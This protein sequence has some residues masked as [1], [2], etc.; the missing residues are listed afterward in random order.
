VSV[1]TLIVALGSAAPIARADVKALDAARLYQEYCA[2]CHGE[3]GDGKSRASQGLAT[4]PRNFTT[5]GL[6]QVLSRERMI[7][8]VWNGRP[9]TAMAA[10]RDRLSRQQVAAIVDFVRSAIMQPVHTDA[11][12]RGAQIYASSCSVCH[13]DRGGGAVW[14]STALQPPPRDFTKAVL[15]RELMVAVVTNGRPTTAMPAFGSQLSPQDIATVVDYI[16]DTFMPRET[17][18][19]KRTAAARSSAAAHTRTMDM[20]IPDGLSGDAAAGRALYETNCVACHGKGGN[21]NGPRAYFIFPRPRNFLAQASRQTLNRPVL[22]HAIKQGIVGREMPAW[23]KVLT[24]QQIADIAE[25]VYQAFIR[26]EA[27]AAKR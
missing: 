1:C 4:P 18:P 20:P 3:K 9:G 19:P 11:P 27:A 14:A 26:A 8:V 17:S 23:G 6:A 16:R 2:V 10:W 5:P 13:G 24:D 7:D 25:H 12:G 21:G 15:P 22:F